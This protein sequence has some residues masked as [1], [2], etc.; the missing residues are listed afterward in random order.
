MF[1]DSSRVDDKTINNIYH[2]LKNSLSKTLTHYFPFAGRVK[3]DFSF[4]CNDSSVPFVEA[5]VANINS[6]SDVLKNPEMDTLQRL[7]PFDPNK[8]YISANDV[9]VAV[10]INHFDCGS[11]AIGLILGIL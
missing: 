4:D 10:Q 7:L 9:N 1:Y 11:V 8:K 6:M 2:R 5:R 3:D